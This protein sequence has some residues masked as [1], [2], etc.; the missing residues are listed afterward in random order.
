MLDLTAHFRTLN[1]KSN[2][3]RKSFLTYRS[4]TVQLATECGLEQISRFIRYL[5]GT[6]RE[7]DIVRAYSTLEYN[8]LHLVSLGEDAIAIAMA[9]CLNRQVQ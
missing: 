3:A 1:M 5:S 7:F 8:G 2:S 4:C 6:V 9:A